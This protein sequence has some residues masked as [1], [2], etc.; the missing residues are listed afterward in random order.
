MFDTGSIASISFDAAL[1]TSV[2][3]IQ[4]FRDK[5]KDSFTEIG[6]DCSAS[7]E[8]IRLVAASAFAV[9]FNSETNI[10]AEAS[11]SNYIVEYEGVIDRIV[12]KAGS[13]SSLT[14]TGCKCRW[15]KSDTQY[16]EITLAS[17][18]EGATIHLYG[19]GGLAI[20]PDGDGKYHLMNGAYR[21]KVDATSDYEAVV[22]IL[23]VS[24]HDKTET[25]K[26]DTVK[27]YK[28]T[29]S[30]TPASATVVVKD[31]SNN[32]MKAIRKGVY[33]LE[34]ST[35]KGN[36]SYTV[37]KTG[38]KTKTGTIDAQASATI[39]VA[40]ATLSSI[41]I[42]TP[43]TTTEYYAGDVFDPTGMA[44]T[45]TFSDSTT[46]VV[47]DY[48]YAPTGALTEE[49]TSITVSYSIGG[50]TKT[51]NQSIT[52]NAVELSSIAITTPP[53]KTAYAVGETFDTTG[54]VVTA[55]YN[56]GDTEEVSDYTYSP[57]TALTVEDTSVTVSYTSEE[58]TK[59]ATQSI[60]V[61]A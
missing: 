2:D 19:V 4:E 55:T 21:V 52:V 3:V 36:Y 60:T 43:P 23:I 16:H 25:I 35:V 14:I 27:K 32:T 22:H 31:S 24:G 42:T 51:A 7:I 41:A 37:S 5:I 57:T 33:E 54:M 15:S 38:Y 12:L 47:T 40:L 53:T 34:D 56:N 28:I 18:P 48:T 44:V 11:G 9:S 50:A 39:T 46:E 26:L 1:D 17:N 59:T 29:F 13:A 6:D 61:T 20:I 58:V 10:S 45:A 49:D 30:L 8:A